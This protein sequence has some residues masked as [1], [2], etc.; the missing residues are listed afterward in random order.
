MLRAFSRSPFFLS[1]RVYLLLGSFSTASQRTGGSE[2]HHRVFDSLGRIRHKSSREDSPS[3]RLGEWR[4]PTR[5]IGASS[6]IG[7]NLVKNYSS[8]EL[9]DLYSPGTVGCDVKD[10]D[11]FLR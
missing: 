2:R 6:L 7:I 8:E 4:Q 10:V 5:G 1:H 3:R 11:V 9:L